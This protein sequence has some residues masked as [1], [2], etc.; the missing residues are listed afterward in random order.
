MFKVLSQTLSW[1]KEGK[2]KLYMVEGLKRDEKEEKERMVRF[3]SHT[4]RRE[5]RKEKDKRREGEREI[6]QKKKK[7][8]KKGNF[9]LDW[10]DLKMTG[11]KFEK[12]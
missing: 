12:F 3:K 1:E 8:K 10:K 7:K 5:G 6:K 9:S 4:Q 2:R 11:L